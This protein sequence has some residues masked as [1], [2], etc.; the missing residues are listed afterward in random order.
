MVWLLS[1]GVVVWSLVVV[2]VG[3]AMA[4]GLL[5]RGRMYGLYDVGHSESVDG[6]EDR[7]V[8]G[9]CGACCAAHS[10]AIDVSGVNCCCACCCHNVIVCCL[11]GV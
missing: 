7:G 10:A 9:D 6:E 3:V 1:M 11:I 8:S 5:L 2:V 4:V